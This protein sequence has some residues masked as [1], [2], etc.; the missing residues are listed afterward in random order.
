MLL[1]HTNTTDSVE[2]VNTIILTVIFRSV[3]VPVRRHCK[4][5]CRCVWS[6]EKWWLSISKD[7]KCLS[8]VYMKVLCFQTRLVIR[9]QRGCLVH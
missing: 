9:Y 1:C 7:A 5:Y 3:C 8:E 6:L 4:L 2:H